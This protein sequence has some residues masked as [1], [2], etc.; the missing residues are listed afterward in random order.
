MLSGLALLVGCENNNG[1]T[2]YTKPPVVAIETPT[3]GASLNEG[4]PV[5]LRGRVVDEVYDTSLT[6]ITATW[7][8]NGGTVCEGAVFDTNGITD[9]STV[10][11]RGDATI[12]LTAI[13]PDGESAVGTV[14]ITVEKNEAPSAEIITPEF[15]GEYFSNQLTLFEG[16]VGDGE[17]LPEE[18]TVS[19]VSSKDGALPFSSNP[20]SD[21]KTTGTTTLSEGEHQLTLTVTDTT[22]RTGSDTTTVQVAAGSRPNIDLVSPKSGDRAN[23]DETVY[24]EATVSDAE[25]APDELTMA[26]ESDLDG[27]FSTRGAGSDGTADFTY[28][29]LSHG[30]HTITVTATD[31][32]GIT[33]R[34][35]ATLYI[36][37]APEAPVVT[38]T[39]DPTGSGDPLT[40]N[41]VTPSYDADGDAITYSYFWYLNGVDAGRTSNPLPA[42]ATTRGDIWTV[43]V[44]P[45]DGAADGPAGTDSATIGNGPPSLTSATI[46]PATA[47]TDDT[48]TANANGYSDPDGD[49]ESE[50]YQW[51]LNGVA[52]AGA[53]DPTLAGSYFVKGDG[54]TVEVKPYDGFDYGAAVTSGTRT[55]QN[56]T[57]TTPA[58]D[59]TPNYPEADDILTCSVVTASTDADGDAITYTYSW[60]VN[61]VA[62]AITTATV[63]ASYTSDGETWLCSV[64]ASDGT[65]T[66]AAGSD[67]ALV[68]DYTAPDAPVLNSLDPYRNETSATVN[69]STEAFADVTLYISSSSGVTTDAGTANGA[70]T[71]SF[72]EA[73]TA[74]VSY[75]FYA[76]ATDSSG[77]TSAVSNVVGTEVCDPADDYEDTT[78]YGDS[79]AD[80]VVDWS[81]LAADG[82]TTIEF[83]GNILDASD[84]DWYYIS[85]SDIVTGTY[86]NYR[87]HVELTAGS[88]EYAFVVYEGGCTSAEL[89]CGSGS[90]TDPEGSGYSEYEVYQEDVGDGSHTIPADYRTCAAGS[91]YNECDDLS[92]DY[93]IHV[94]RT[95]TAYSC[96]EYSLK[97]TNGVW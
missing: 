64:T 65:A 27:I 54:V 22:G 84:D 93:Y 62:S 34:D 18:L 82:T 68:G 47:Y 74:G 2:K 28:D 70:G 57:P 45:N 46:T 83:N 42:S 10:F 26:W 81:T 94:F 24:F 55:I 3:D 91:T 35:Y 72:S 89:E 56:S 30:V 31:T 75:S 96:Q 51:Y 25:D 85:T 19:W 78:A 97:I 80:P 58:V 6:S 12:T 4:V 71:F 21:G 44:V 14:H 69:G 73:L 9:C 50:A 20:S 39:P 40:V 5:S 86:N 7:A 11:T 15:G 29:A 23:I 53:T 92:G 90:S 33:S 95:S 67:S 38:I 88:S 63:A 76:T 59:V 79:C 1:V 37:E 77:N 60:T 49:A 41:I 66:S 36:N 52:I 17:D 61:G 32:D 8:V 16:L 87:F 48:L 43:Y 13:N